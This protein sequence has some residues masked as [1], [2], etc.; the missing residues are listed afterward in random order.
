MKKLVIV[1]SIWLIF[2][3]PPAMDVL[4]N[5]NIIPA[6]LSN[7]VVVF[8]L[9]LLFMYLLVFLEASIRVRKIEIIF[10]FFIVNVALVGL[11]NGASFSFVLKDMAVLG[12]GPL[13]FILGRSCARSNVVSAEFV[14]ESARRIGLFFFMVLL[15]YPYISIVHLLI[16]VRKSLDPK[17]CLVLAALIAS[18]VITSSKSIVLALLL[19]IFLTEGWKKKLSIVLVS[20]VVGFGISAFFQDSDLTIVRKTLAFLDSFSLEELIFILS[21][22][23]PSAVWSFDTAT[24]QRL[25]EFLLVLQNIDFTSCVFGHGLGYGIDLRDSQDQSIEVRMTEGGLEDVRSFH[26]IFSWLLAKTGVLGFLLVVLYLRFVW[27]SI[28]HDQ[29]FVV[30]FSIFVSLAIVTFGGFSLN[31]PYLFI[32]GYLGYI[33]NAGV[34]SAQA[35]LTRIEIGHRAPA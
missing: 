19:W 16:F 33:R 3:V 2:L 1:S 6:Q 17:N 27:R 21:N 20:A 14:K 5:L 9:L 24:A 30:L 31:Y 26:L 10:L 32:L 7:L 15:V 28:R 11:I 25:Y 4:S 18:V 34:A 29:I 35:T 8:P 23:D 12:I 22:I 13:A